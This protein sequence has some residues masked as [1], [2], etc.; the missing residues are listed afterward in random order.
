MK[1]PPRV[2]LLLMW[3]LVVFSAVLKVSHAQCESCSE[4]NALLTT[5]TTAF[6]SGM[7]NCSLTVGDIS[8][9]GTLTGLTPGTT[10]IVHLSCLECC[11]NVTTKPAEVRNLAVNSVTTSSIAVSWTEPV[12]AV[13]SYKV[14]WA[15]GMMEAVANETSKLI[16]E[17]ASGTEY[18]ITVSAVAQ[19]GLTEGETAAVS[20]YTRP[21]Q[22]QDLAVIEVTTSSIRV[23]WSQPEGERLL[24]KVEWTDGNMENTSATTIDISSLSAGVQHQINVTAVAADRRTMGASKHVFQYTRPGK[25]LNSTVFSNTTSIWLSWSPPAGRMLNYR[26][27][28]HNNGERLNRYTAQ[29]SA[30]LSHL[31]PGVEYAIS[32]V[33]IAQ[34]NTTEG[35]SITLFQF[36]KPAVVRN[37]SIVELTTT[38]V[39]LSWTPPEGNASVY[40]LNWTDGADM[41]SNVTAGT[42]FA[43]VNLTPG[44]QHDIA[45]TA[46][47]GNLNNEGEKTWIMT[48]TRPEKPPRVTVTPATDSLSI[49]WMLLSG[50]ADHYVLNVSNE[51]LMYSHSSITAFTTANVAGLQPG[52]LYNVTVTSVAGDLLNTSD[53]NSFATVPTPPGSI[54]ISERTNSSLHLWWAPPSMMADAPNVSYFISYRMSSSESARSSTN[55]IVLSRLSSGTSYTVIV[56][57][58][59]PQNLMSSGVSETSFTIPNPVLN[60]VARPLNTTSITVEWSDPLGVQWFYSYR[61]ITQLNGTI[62]SSM[63]VRGTKA[64]VHGLEPGT[65]YR[66]AVATMAAPESVSEPEQTDAYTKPEAVTGLREEHVNATVI[67]LTWIRQSDHKSSYSYLVDMYL[68]RTKILNVTTETETYTFYNLIPGRQYSFDVYTVVGGVKSVVANTSVQTRPQEVSN[69]TVVGGTT[70]ISVMWTQAPGRVDSYDVFLRRDSWLINMSRVYNSTRTT[71]EG[72]TPGV[73]Y[74]AEVVTTAA[75]LSSSNSS[76]CNATV[77][78]PPGPITVESQTVHSVNFTWAHPGGMDHDQ[79][80]F[81]VSTFNGSHVTEDNWFLLDELEPGTLYNI[82]V[83]TLGLLGYKSTAVTGSGYTLPNPVLNLVARPLNT[84]SITVE[85]SDPLGVQDFYSY[86][87]ITQLN[88]TIKSSMEVRGTKADVHGLE[89]GTRYRIAVATMAA[90]ESVSE[91]EQTDAYTKPE[92]VTGLRGEHVNATVIQLTW[93]RQSDHKSSYSYLVDMYLDRTK[94]LNVTTETETYTFYNLIPGRQYSFDVYTVVGGVKSTVANTSVHTIPETVEPKIS[95]QGS[96][97]SVLVTW[98]TPPG[99]VEY[100]I[101]TL[102][103]SLMDFEPRR[104]SNDTQE[105]LFDSLSAGVLYTV[106]VTTHSG[107]SSASS[108]PVTN[109]TFPNRPGPIEI[110]KKTTGSVTLQWAEPIL[111]ENAEFHY[112]VEISPFGTKFAWTTDTSYTFELLDSGTPYPITVATVGAMNLESDPV[113]INSV[114][115]RPN[116]VKGPSLSTEED[117]I[118]VTWSHPDQYKTSYRYFLTWRSSDLSINGSAT[119][120]KNEFTI[121]RLMP[122]TRYSISITTE[123]VDGTR[124]RPKWIDDCTDASPVN[125][126]AIQSPNTSNAKI[127]VSWSKPRGHHQRVKLSIAEANIVQYTDACLR[128]C[129]LT[130][131]NLSHYTEYN[132]SLETL[133]CGHPS[134]PVYISVRTG[135]TEPNIPENYESLSKVDDKKYNQFSVKIDSKLLV[136]NQGPITSVGV[137]I[138][139]SPAGINAADMKKYLG[140]T[141][142]EWREEKTPAYLAIVRERDLNTRRNM[143]DMLIVVGDTSKWQGYENGFLSGNTRYHYA[144][145]L[146]TKVSL[147]RGL[148]DGRSSIVSITDFYPEVPLPYDPV[149]IGVAVGAPL[150]IFCMLFIVLIGFIVY[151]RRL[152]TKESSDIQIHSM[153]SAAV[154]VEDFEAFYKKQKADSNCGFAEEFEDLKVVGTG[155]PKL[156]AIS[157]ENKPKNRYNNVLPYDSSR[158]KLS[159]SGSPYDDYI[160]A[161]YMPGYHSRKEFIA[162]QGPLP[163]TLNE[164]WRMI[165]E[166]NVQTVVMLTRCVEQGKIK[167]EQYWTEDTKHYANITVTK[168]SEIPLDDW[169]IREFDIKNVK[170]AETRTIRHFHFTAWPDH[171]VPE[172]TELLISFRHLVRE[173]MDQY[174]KCSPT[175]VHCSAGVGRT[176]TFIAIDRLVFQIERENVVDIYGAVHD[177]RLHRPFMVQ[178][179]AQYV[180]LNQC[181]LDIIKSR[182]GT[183]VDLIYQNTAAF[184]IYENLELKRLK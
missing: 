118:K 153:G 177:L 151:W 97:S 56:R 61:V 150:G 121:N 161:N 171:G 9:N 93:I 143:E 80:T 91:P 133:S 3:T 123:T 54:I 104:L 57:T 39:S 85:W 81:I 119:V 86:R 59:G 60:L 87:V 124:G 138:T 144:I 125:D 135:V 166:K 62:K 95:S 2:L 101:V 113:T 88:G 26:L 34:D 184:S 68:D 38:S 33:S 66:I 176:G 172:T 107:P 40:I 108:E 28:W 65:R 122:G 49:S 19:D 129:G 35:D 6:L 134:K 149:F 58:V 155:Q 63:E 67:Q 136:S 18:T 82:S 179:E 29:E 128:S 139:D 31:T 163:G 158:V 36:T 167:C 48:F 152:A 111:M 154:K 51:D 99:G 183:N 175:V 10:Y 159:I 92:A 117:K 160:N 75:N 79:Y 112:R 21:N 76:V 110:L 13:S 89:P 146:F 8:G 44:S 47:V 162:A 73:R 140:K 11:Q 164:F 16:T 14:Q 106:V 170:T 120:M 5:T 145:A 22:V 69:V 180:F 116:T 103:G 50:R 42:S 181:A 83:V 96:N 165:W 55:S 23:N 84:T 148:V 46:A 169:T 127:I 4:S 45:V 74:C 182:T 27:T 157:L 109:A 94:I 100:Y 115:T 41:F 72:L 132:L 77:P 137:L 130:I 168:T 43:I 25:I 32:L 78:T 71:F 1:P 173:H 114:T 24:Y 105:F 20:Q 64:D 15:D 178:T 12:G 90:P 53:V 174:S 52:R 30:V 98:N 141:Y 147:E 126:I 131:S 102:N 70:G 156:S 17:L 142:E 37:L 7:P